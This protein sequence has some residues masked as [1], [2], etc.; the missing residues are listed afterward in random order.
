M[1]CGIKNNIIRMLCN[2]GAEV[3]LVPW[4]HDLAADAHKVSNTPLAVARHR[5]TLSTTIICQLVSSRDVGIATR[6]PIQ[7]GLL[8]KVSWQV[9]IR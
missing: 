7:V 4:N 2:K 8:R 3:T 5:Y 9:V 1:D 6:M